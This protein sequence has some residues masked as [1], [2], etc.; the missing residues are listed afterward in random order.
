MIRVPR[1][2]TQWLKLEQPF[3]AFRSTESSPVQHTEM[4]GI[5]LNFLP[6]ANLIEIIKYFVM[7]V[8]SAVFAA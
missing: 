4:V 5:L 3:H 6:C 1:A 2:F 8:E 7:L